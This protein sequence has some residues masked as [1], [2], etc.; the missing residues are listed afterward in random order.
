MSPDERRVVAARVH[1]GAL[2]PLAALELRLSQLRD[3]LGPDVEASLL[4]S[5]ERCAAQ[6]SGR[7]R[8][9]MRELGGAELH[10]ESQA[11][12]RRSA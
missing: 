1:D 10:G 5:I 4:D 7:L 12:L 6:A 2:Q 8:E 9:L 11:E 3:R